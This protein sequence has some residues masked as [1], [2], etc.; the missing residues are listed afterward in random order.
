M[1]L[2]YSYQTFNKFVVD[3]SGTFAGA[4]GWVDITDDAEIIGD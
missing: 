3:A 1:Q 2:L 4:G